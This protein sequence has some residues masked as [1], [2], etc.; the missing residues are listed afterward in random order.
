MANQAPPPPESWAAERAKNREGRTAEPVEA[1]LDEP[2]LV[3]P[4]Q[5]YRVVGP[6]AVFDT[7]PGDTVELA[8]TEGQE[9][10]LIEAGHLALVANRDVPGTSVEE[11][12]A[13]D[14]RA[15]EPVAK[16]D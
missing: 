9:L 16:E 1:P 15:D 12:S 4:K 11:D 14:N 13:D 10:N 6:H 7:A 2:N 3:L 8:L 5:V